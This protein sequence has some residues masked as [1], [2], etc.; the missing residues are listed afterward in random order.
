MV[1]VENKRKL[2]WCL[3]HYDLSE[4]NCRWA[5]KHLEI[6]ARRFQQ[7]Y[8]EYKTTGK[9]PDIGFDVGRPKK[10]LPDEW[11]KIIKLEYEKTC[12]NAVYLEKTINARHG[13][14]IPHNV[15]H[16]VLLELEYAEHE[17]SKQKRRK[18][19]IRYER[20]HSLSLVHMDWHHCDNG[21]YLISVLDDASRKILA[22]GEFDNET[23]ENSLTVLKQA[24]DKC[25]PLY[26]ILSVV[27]DHGSQFYANKRDAKGYAEHGFEQFLEEYGIRHILCGVNHPQ[28]NG[29]IEKWHD[30]YIH[31]RSR[32]SS[33][34]GLVDWYNFE[35]P[36]G[37]LNLR[38]AE[39][40]SEAFIRKMRPEVWLGLGAEVFRW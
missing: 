6:T 24:Y 19:W 29:K 34:D 12:S 20:H 30:L 1:K 17:E 22:A 32:F 15:I 28:T 8:K 21:K 5:S 10:K 40:P 27:T 25:L 16:Q 31:H 33:L 3:V 2:K 39:T 11:K 9:I 38:R 18:P 26:S 14:H 23:T 35:R 7:L 36:H 37:S 13:I 4:V